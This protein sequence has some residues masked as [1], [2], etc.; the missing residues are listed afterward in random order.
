M[1]NYHLRH[2]NKGI[3]EIFQGAYQYARTLFSSGVDI[4]IAITKAESQ[5]SLEINS[6]MWCRLRDLS[7]QVKWPINGVLSEMSEEDWKCLMT[8]ALQEEERI[9]EGINGGRVFLGKSTSKM[10]QGE[11]HD[12]ITV[13]EMFGATQGVKWTESRYERQSA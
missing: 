10:T 11:M 3:K 12:L 5:R 9:A 8:A 2:G 1:S 6:V 4:K 7:R 13:I